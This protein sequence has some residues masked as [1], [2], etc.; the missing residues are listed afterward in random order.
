MISL[1]ISLVIS[2]TL[3]LIISLTLS[4]TLSLTISLV[5]LRKRSPA[6]AVK[7]FYV[8]FMAAPSILGGHL[9][10]WEATHLH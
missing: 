6:S 4:L 7:W 3:S 1:T 9:Q 2:L 5:A 8:L 10:Y